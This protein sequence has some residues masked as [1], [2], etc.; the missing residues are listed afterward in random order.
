MGKG[1]EVLQPPGA[2][3]AMKARRKRAWGISHAALNRE[4]TTGRGSLDR[5][6]VVPDFMIK[7]ALQADDNQAYDG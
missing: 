7:I 3:V 2:G 4:W 6:L 5:L 1:H